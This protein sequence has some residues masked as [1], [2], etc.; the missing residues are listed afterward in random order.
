MKTMENK[1]GWRRVRVKEVKG[2]LTCH[3]LGKDIDPKNGRDGILM[4]LEYTRTA[5]GIW[6]PGVATMLGIDVGLEA[7]GSDV[8]WAPARANLDGGGR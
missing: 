4:K 1:D 8:V 3:I 2:E 5:M 7:R 6:F